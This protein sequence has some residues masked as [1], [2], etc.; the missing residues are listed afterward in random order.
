M[1]LVQV[2]F[3]KN[4][5]SKIYRNMKL[6]SLNFDNGILLTVKWIISSILIFYIEITFM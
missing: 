4:L 6:L 3:F 1:H 5:L 2:D